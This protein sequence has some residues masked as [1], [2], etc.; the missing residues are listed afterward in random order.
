MSR[1]KMVESRRDRRTMATEA[2]FGSLSVPSALAGVFCAFGTFAVVAAIAGVGLAASGVENAGDITGDRRDLGIGAA[3]VLSLVL[4]VSYLFGGYVAGRMSRRAGASNGALVFVLGLLIV[5]GVGAAVGMQTDPE[6]I[7]SD[8]RGIGVPTSGDE[9]AALGSI[10]GIAAL[11]SMLIGSMVGGIWGERWHGRLLTRALDP[12]VGPDVDLRDDHDTRSTDRHESTLDDDRA[13]T[14]ERTLVFSGQ[15]TAGSHFRDN[16][17]E[18]TRRLDRTDTTADDDLG[19]AT[20]EVRPEPKMRVDDSVS[21]D[22]TRIDR[23]GR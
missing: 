16:D 17:D 3:I 10:A 13:R 20:R 7:R 23:P 18:S 2:G 4:F 12:T 8:L 15:P 9:W 21:D 1:T 6:V 22:N 19:G 14:R 11:L 5:G